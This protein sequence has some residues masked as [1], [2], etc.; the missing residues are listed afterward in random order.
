MH[1]IVRNHKNCVKGEITISGAKNAALPILIASLLLPRSEII[2]IPIVRDIII[3]LLIIKKLGMNYQW[4]KIDY[5]TFRHH[6][7]INSTTST[8][9]K[10]FPEVPKSL[11]QQVRISILL[12]GAGITKFGKI[13]LY[14]PGGCKLG[15]RPINYH[16]RALRKLG[17]RI[18]IE[19]DAIIAYGD[20]VKGGEIVLPYPSVGTT[21]N[22]IL[23]AIGAKNS[24]TIYNAAIEPEILNMINFLKRAGV[25]I[26]VLI[27]QRMI[28]IEGTPLEN[29][30]HVNKYEI[31]P[32]RIEAF[33]YCVLT[34]ICG[35]KIKL[36]NIDPSLLQIPIQ[37]L[38][39]LG[40]KVTTRQNELE[41][42]ADKECLYSDDFMIVTEP[43]PG[44]PTDDHPLLVPLLLSI[45]GFGKI[46]ENVYL[47]RFRY[48]NELSKLGAKIEVNRITRTL[49]IIGPQRLKGA[50][51]QATDL[52]G[53]MAVLLAG[54][55]AKGITIIKNAKEIFRGYEFLSNK[56]QNVGI[57][58]EFS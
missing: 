54:L 35:G 36:K 12:L 41:I 24:T 3:T 25:G 5:K 32:D 44:F 27:N 8:R 10:L 22:I 17:A 48:I 46:V 39:D 2:R 47:E 21:E 7:T 49:T 52:R 1:L 13:K 18:T 37:V 9:N 57:K 20:N 45:R 28:E 4:N 56:L 29:L 30:T 19:D 42:T 31:I 38:K 6:L 55:Y 33:T 16:L 26:K 51:V 40:C 43:Y 14:L 53:G 34:G 11:C 50:E 15:V 23:A 58:I